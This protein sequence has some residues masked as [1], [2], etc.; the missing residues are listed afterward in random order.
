M[1]QKGT[2]AKTKDKLRQLVQVDDKIIREYCITY[3]KYVKMKYRLETT[4]KNAKKYKEMASNA[5][6]DEE[7][8]GKYME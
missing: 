5:E 6:I 1:K 2:P 3:Y 7:E 4:Y 8:Q